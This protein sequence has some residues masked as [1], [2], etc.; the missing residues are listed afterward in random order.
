MHPCSTGR[1]KQSAKSHEDQE[2]EF[3]ADSERSATKEKSDS[4]EEVSNLGLNESDE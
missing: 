2:G 1:Q 4:A 3:A